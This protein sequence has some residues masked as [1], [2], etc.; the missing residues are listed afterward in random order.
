VRRL[1]FFCSEK[2]EPNYRQSTLW[3]T[4][5]W[6]RH[7]I[8]GAEQAFD[9]RLPEVTCQSPLA[10]I[11]ASLPAAGTRVALDNYE[12]PS[13]LSQTELVTRY[14]TSSPW[15]RH[16]VLALGPERGWSRTERDLLRAGGFTFVHL[17]PRVLR[18]ET[19]VAA[20]VAVVKAKLGLM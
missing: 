5:E 10:E 7:L 8:A 13:A 4:G 9:T 3:S 1:H 17:G 18:V 11:L 2:G 6:R 14:V 12:S 19:A 15:E 20:A 16:V